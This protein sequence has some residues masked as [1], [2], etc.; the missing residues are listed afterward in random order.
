MLESTVYVDTIHSPYTRFYVIQCV[1]LCFHVSFSNAL[2]LYRCVCVFEPFVFERFYAK[3]TY[4]DMSYCECVLGN[5]LHNRPYFPAAV[6]TVFPFYHTIISFPIFFYLLH[7]VVLL[8]RYVLAHVTTSIKATQTFVLRQLIYVFR[9]VNTHRQ[10]YSC[11]VV[12]KTTLDP[13]AHFS[14]LGSVE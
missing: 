8:A 6:A 9:E 10:R 12:Y 3:Y 11:I 1:L 5:I 7:S 4:I 2:T 14:S 13:F